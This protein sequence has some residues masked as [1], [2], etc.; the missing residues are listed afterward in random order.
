MPDHSMDSGSGDKIARSFYEMVVKS[1]MAPTNEPWDH[2]MYMHPRITQ[3]S[4]CKSIWIP[5]QT[6]LQKSI[7]LTDSSHMDIGVEFSSKP[8]PAGQFAKHSDFR[9]TTK[10]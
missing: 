1:A 3:R 8:I 4:T 7:E 2:V 5:V 10:R 9:T 6:Q